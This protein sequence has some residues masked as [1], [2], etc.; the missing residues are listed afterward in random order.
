MKENIFFPCILPI[1]FFL[2][3]LSESYCIFWTIPLIF[4]SIKVLSFYLLSGRFPHLVAT[5][6]LD[7]LVFCGPILIFKSSVLLSRTHLYSIPFL[8]HGFNIFLSLRILM[9]FSGCFINPVI[10]LFSSEN[11]FFLVSSFHVEDSVQMSD[12]AVTLKRAAPKAEWK[13]HVFVFVTC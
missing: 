1:A 5:L 6:L 8:F 12:D 10:I 7:F 9:I 13:L 2:E 11:F 3:L 4:F